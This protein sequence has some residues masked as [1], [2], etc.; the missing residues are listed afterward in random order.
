MRE[1]IPQDSGNRTQPIDLWIR[2]LSNQLVTPFRLLNMPSSTDTQLSEAHSQSNA[3][4]GEQEMICSKLEEGSK[5]VL[6]RGESRYRRFILQTWVPVIHCMFCTILSLCL[7]V[8]LDGRQLKPEERKSYFDIFRGDTNL[9][10]S[11][12]TT[13]VSS[14][15]MVTRTVSQS[16]MMGVAWRCAM[17]LLQHDGLNLGQLNRMVSY[18]VPTAWTGK[19]AWLIALVLILLL[20]SRVVSP[21]LSGSIDWVAED[22]YVMGNEA[23]QI[24]GGFGLRLYT[25]SD[26][27]WVK[28]DQGSR[29]GAVY[30]ALGYAAQAFFDGQSNG[31]DWGRHR[32][33]AWDDAAL[34]TIVEDVPMPYIDIHSISW[35]NQFETWTDDIFRE[36]YRTFYTS[37]SFFNTVGI[38]IFFKEKDAQFPASE[39]PARVITDAWKFAVLVGR[40]SDQQKQDCLSIATSRWD[41]LSESH[42]TLKHIS[43]ADNCWAQATVNFTIGIRYFERGI[44]VGNR[45]VEALPDSINN[46]PHMVGDTWAEYALYLV[47]DMLSSLPVVKRG[48]IVDHNRNLTQYAEGLIRQ[49]YLSMRA[50]LYPY[51]PPTANL[52]SQRPISYLTAQV[53]QMRVWIWLALNLLLPLSAVIM[54]AVESAVEKSGRG[55]NSL[56]DT[57]LAPLLTDVRDILVED[58]RGISNMSYLTN[59]DTKS[60]GKLR[61]TPVDIP[62]PVGCAYAVTKKCVIA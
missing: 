16:F 21:L 30:T 46:S 31:S 33:I 61:L 6:R 45:I 13:L 62:G 20:P 25:E 51:R 39:Q 14:A 17:V 3:L 23:S 59:E 5:P 9:R 22:A 40:G 58:E 28:N 19:Y 49:S 34:N 27:W 36:P 11:D 53:D 44:Y 50:V 43:G 18:R 2:R 37:L 8:F 15:L 4:L 41:G 35:D 57:V 1:D 42:M 29:V 52:K 10:V 55:R 24:L 32:Y 56:V 54:L 47:S 7:V 26:W 60:I 38:S 48:N 12:V